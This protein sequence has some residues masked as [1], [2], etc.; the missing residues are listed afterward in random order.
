MTKWCKAYAYALYKKNMSFFFFQTHNHQQGKLKDSSHLERHNP[1]ILLTVSFRSW[2]VTAYLARTIHEQYTVR[3]ILC[4]VHKVQG[5]YVI[6]KIS[7]T[8]NGIFF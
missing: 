2:Q 7:L 6:S 1:S 3:Y 8:P 5:T 4:L